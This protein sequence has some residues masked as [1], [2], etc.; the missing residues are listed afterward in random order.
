MKVGR[1]TWTTKYIKRGNWLEANQELF[2]LYCFRNVSKVMCKHITFFEMHFLQKINVIFTCFTTV[3]YVDV[4]RRDSQWRISYGET[5]HLAL[6]SS[7]SPPCWAHILSALLKERV[8]CWV[9]QVSATECCVWSWLAK[10][11]ILHMLTPGVCAVS[12]RSLPLL[13]SGCDGGMENGEW[14]DGEWRMERWSRSLAQ[15]RE[16]LPNAPLRFSRLLL[17]HTHCWAQPSPPLGL[18][19][20]KH[21]RHCGHESIM[22]LQVCCRWEG[23][24]KIKLLRCWG[25]L[26]FLQWFR[27]P[28]C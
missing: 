11:C 7:T 28:P 25:H 16:Y 26:N 13:T 8:S 20:S 23:T 6:G 3:D 17:L 5:P 27:S 1:N 14:L 21:L 22:H 10:R 24:Y 9:P 15:L 2:C 4:C 19:S 12:P 18:V